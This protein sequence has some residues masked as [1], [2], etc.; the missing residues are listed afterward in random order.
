MSHD[1]RPARM[2]VVSDA[3]ASRGNAVA[4]DATGTPAQQAA[5]KAAAEAEAPKG[6]PIV[7]A[8]MFLV[9]CGA[10][11]ALVTMLVAGGH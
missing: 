11:G 6:L 2:R 10:G 4:A 7:P 8:L 9:A 5:A 1:Q 3:A